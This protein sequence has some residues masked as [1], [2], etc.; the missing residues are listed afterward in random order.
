MTERHRYRCRYFAYYVERSK[1]GVR[2][3]KSAQVPEESGLH[4]LGGY[5]HKYRQRPADKRVEIRSR[6]VKTY[7]RYKAREDGSRQNRYDEGGEVHKLTAHVGFYERLHLCYDI[8]GYNLTLRYVAHPHIVGKEFTQCE[9]ENQH[10]YAVDL[11][12]GNGYSAE[13][14]Y[15]EQNSGAVYT[16]I[17]SLICLF[18][19]IFDIRI[20]IGPVAAEYPV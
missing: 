13:Y 11:R 6:R 14:R 12:F 10:E 18:L 1:H 8:F 20:R 2:P 9:H 3:G 15:Y 5:K 7:Q 4:L 17:Q 16:Y 19:I